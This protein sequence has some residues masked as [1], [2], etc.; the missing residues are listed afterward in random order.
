MEAWNVRRSFSYAPYSTEVQPPVIFSRVLVPPLSLI[1]NKLSP[2]NV[3]S[4][5][6]QNFLAIARRKNQTSYIFSDLR[7]H[8]NTKRVKMTMTRTVTM[9][10]ITKTKTKND[11]KH[12]FETIEHNGA[13]TFVF[14]FP[15]LTNIIISVERDKRVLSHLIQRLLRDHNFILSLKF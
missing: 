8:C 5:T 14:L 4:R 13:K 7:M 12:N 2:I 3:P 9:T 10:I 15:F 1:R 11:I 6:Q